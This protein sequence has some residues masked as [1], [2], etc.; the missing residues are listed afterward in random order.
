MVLS[1]YYLLFGPFE[2]KIIPG[3]G[4]DSAPLAHPASYVYDS[5]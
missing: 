4:V 2:E 1:E 5:I 3:G